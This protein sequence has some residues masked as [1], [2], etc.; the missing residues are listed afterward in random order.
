MEKINYGELKEKLEKN[1]ES[2]GNPKEGKLFPLRYRQVLDFFKRAYRK[3]GIPI[4]KQPCHIWRHTSAQD[5]LEATNW[6]YELCAEILGWED[7]RT[8]KACYGALSESKK[9]ETLLKAMGYPIKKK[10]KFF[11]F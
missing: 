1:L 8:L 3:A 5:F 2:R 11:K 4:P 10:K 6:N 7:T 9:E